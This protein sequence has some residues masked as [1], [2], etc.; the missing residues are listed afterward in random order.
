MST[1]E[2]RKI[3]K[4]D[5]L[6]QFKKIEGNRDLDY[7]HVA[8]LRE[9]I[10]NDNKLA[11]APIIVNEHYEV[12]DGQHRLQVAKELGLEIYFDIVVGANKD[13]MI[14]LNQNVQNWKPRDFAE[15]WARKGVE[16]YRVYLDFIKQYGLEHRT[17]MYLFSDFSHDH[18]SIKTFRNGEFKATTEQIEWAHEQVR[19]L[20][21]F[22]Q[23]HSRYLKRAFVIAATRM[24]N[25]IGYSH[26]HMMSRLSAQPTSLVPCVTAE[27]YVQVLENIFNYNLKRQRVYFNGK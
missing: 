4:T 27:A 19:M 11:A 22:G 14:V 8:R 12:I 6:K 18:N 24:F 20:F 9:S 3:Y 21:D 13:A 2:V 10:R 7:A 5:D 23:Y 25:T 16:S 1:V 26:E 15:Y 17:L